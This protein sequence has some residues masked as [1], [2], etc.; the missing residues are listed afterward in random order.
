MALIKCKEC[1]KEISDTAKQCPHCGYKKKKVK[2]FWPIIIIL[3]I[4]G[5]LGEDEITKV[6]NSVDVIV[7][8]RKQSKLTDTV[9]PL[10]PLEAMAWRKLVIT[11]SVRGM[12]ELVKH[13]DTG[14]VFKTDELESIVSILNISLHIF[15]II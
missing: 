7:N 6:Y 2:L 13:R 1:K 8:P 10:K 15:F 12:Q 4:I 14:L 3:I 9:T 5:Y 11:S